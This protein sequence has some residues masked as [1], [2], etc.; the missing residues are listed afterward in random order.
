MSVVAVQI[1][2]GKARFSSD[3]IRVTGWTQEKETYSKLE[4]F[5]DSLVVGFCGECRY[6]VMLKAFSKTHMPAEGSVDAVTEWFSEFAGWISKVPNFAVDMG[7]ATYLLAF[8]GKV[9]LFSNYFCREV[10]DHYAI[11]AGSDFALAA[12]HLGHAPEE[13]VKVA[14]ELSAF[15]EAPVCSLEVKP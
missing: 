6:R 14:C 8:G 10:K 1:R 2:A 13:A 11:G 7:M 15:C 3:S 9:F 4:K 12:L 5:S